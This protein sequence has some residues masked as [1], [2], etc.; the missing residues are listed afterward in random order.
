MVMFRK[1]ESG[2]SIGTLDF[3]LDFHWRGDRWV[4]ELAVASAGG[5]V[6]VVQSF[7]SDPERDDPRRVVSPTYQQMEIQDSPNGPGALLLG[8]S[9]QHHF[10]AVFS[11]RELGR[12]V[13]VEVDVADRCRTP[14]EA[15]A[16]TYKVLLATGDLQGATAERVVWQPSWG[17]AAEL[18]LIG[19]ETTRVI[20][21]EGGRQ[22]MRVQADAALD[23]KDSTHRC[24]Y[25][26]LWL[27]SGEFA[28]AARPDSSSSKSETAFGSRPGPI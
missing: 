28:S 20:V 13:E 15:L 23:P 3:R 18:H 25:R 1:S 8:Q 19:T 5:F 4:H 22:G 2:G 26:W 10:S 24:K 21:A 12:G 7:E 14:V 27:R 9:G 17:N 16:A 11:V 6:R